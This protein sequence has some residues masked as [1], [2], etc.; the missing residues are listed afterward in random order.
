MN[1]IYTQTDIGGVSNARNI[2]L[3]LAT[4]EYITFL[5]DDD[6]FSEQTLA[7]LYEKA[8]PNIIT[9]FKPLAFYDGTKEYFPYS[10]TVEYY[11]N[12]N[13]NNIP[14]YR[15]RKNFSGPV[16]K[17]FPTSIIGTRRYNKKFKN[18]ED[19]LFM[20]LISDRIKK[21]NFAAEDAIYYRRIRSNSAATSTKSF[22]S[23]FKNSCKLSGEYTKIFFLNIGHYN[24]LFFLTRILGSIRALL[25]Y[26]NVTY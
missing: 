19:S 12:F 26:K 20:F 6:F 7:R 22:I 4:G 15:V 10:R 3:D 8:T 1:I 18:G 13:K 16:M 24:F 9:I 21:V 2:A 14:F 11:K 25:N 23:V 5:D 17:M